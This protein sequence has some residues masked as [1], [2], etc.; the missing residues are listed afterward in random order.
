MDGGER[1]SHVA[2]FLQLAC[3]RAHVKSGG[4]DYCGGHSAVGT[5]AFLTLQYP[6]MGARLRLDGVGFAFAK[7]GCTSPPRDSSCLSADITCVVDG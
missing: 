1:A 5:A 6:P 2:L 7:N 4:R 3:L